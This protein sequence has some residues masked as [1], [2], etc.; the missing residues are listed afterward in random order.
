MQVSSRELA[1]KPLQGYEKRKITYEVHKSRL[2]KQCIADVY[3]TKNLSHDDVRKVCVHVAHYVKISL[4]STPK[5]GMLTNGVLADDGHR[6]VGDGCRTSP[7]PFV[8]NERGSRDS[9]G[10]RKWIC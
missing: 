7:A 4:P 1:G 6:R 2:T 8:L 5:R 10:V 3:P 9:V